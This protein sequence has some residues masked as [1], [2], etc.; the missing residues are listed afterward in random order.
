MI[1][2]SEGIKE[3]LFVG[4]ETLTGEKY[5]IPFYVIV[6]EKFQ[7]VFQNKQKS[8]NGKS[9]LVD[10]DLSLNQKNQNS[11]NGKKSDLDDQDSSLNENKN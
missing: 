5:A 6:V 1:D 2:R 4:L 8:K 10:Q 3:S 11:K 9:D 7:P